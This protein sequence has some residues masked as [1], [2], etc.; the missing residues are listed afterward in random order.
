MVIAE[1]A[2]SARTILLP[3]KGDAELLVVNCFVGHPSHHL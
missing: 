1:M 2:E 3:S